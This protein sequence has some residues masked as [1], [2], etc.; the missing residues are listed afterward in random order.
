MHFGPWEVAAFGG[1][2][3]SAIILAADA[4][5]RMAPNIKIRFPSMG[6]VQDTAWWGFTPLILLTAAGIIFLIDA[7]SWLPRNGAS[8]SVQATVPS[9]LLIPAQP[10]I[11][12][13]ADEAAAT[14]PS[15]GKK[16][17]ELLP[18]SH[19]FQAAGNGNISIWVENIGIACALLKENSRAICLDSQPGTMDSKWFSLSIARMEFKPSHDK[20]PPNGFFGEHWKEFKSAGFSDW[21]CL[22]DPGTVWYQRFENGVIIGPV[23]I[24]IG[25]IFNDRSRILSIIN[26]KTWSFIGAKSSAPMCRD[27]WRP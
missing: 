10:L 14:N 15:L 19:A 25:E 7:L 12:K 4:G 3:V 2:L 23:R 1:L 27:A 26:K 6:R 11:T 8:T 21:D 18:A 9:A 24:A 13:D 5:L 22:F 17:T 16:L 20:L